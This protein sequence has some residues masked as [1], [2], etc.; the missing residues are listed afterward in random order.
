[1][2]NFMHTL[3]V[4]E[5]KVGDKLYAKTYSC[6]HFAPTF[7]IA[8]IKKI[9]PTGKIRLDSGSLID[10]TRT[11]LDKYTK[12][13]E[14]EKVKWEI[15]E[16]LVDS[17]TVIE[18]GS[19]KV[20]ED[21]PM[22]KIEALLYHLIPIVGMLKD[23]AHQNSSYIN[24]LINTIPTQYKELLNLKDKLLSETNGGKR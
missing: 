15:R 8:T 11:H 14:L 23:Y 5:L 17:I 2:N 22:N 7:H 1:M 9:T 3:D 18:G 21:M 13:V 12:E 16:I 19:P 6:W 20:F 4:K 24:H 10:P